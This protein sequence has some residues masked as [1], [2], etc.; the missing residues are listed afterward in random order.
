MDKEELFNRI[1]NFWYNFKSDFRKLMVF[2]WSFVHVRILVLSLA[3]LNAINWYFAYYISSEIGLEKIALHYSVDFGIDF[4][5]DTDKVYTLPF[6]S[7]FVFVF[8]YFLCLFLVK[9]LKPD[10]KFMSYLLLLSA[11]IVEIVLLG[12]TASIYYINFR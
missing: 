8:N 6:L 4:Y 12:A 7:L 2:S 11:L 5:G 3:F 9:Y 1:V 10:F